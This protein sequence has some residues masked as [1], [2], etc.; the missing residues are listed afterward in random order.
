MYGKGPRDKSQYAR[1]PCRHMRSVACPVM[2]SR[3]VRVPPPRDVLG[4][5]GAPDRLPPLCPVVSVVA[6]DLLALGWRRNEQRRRY[7]R[8][9]LFP[10][11]L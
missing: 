7:G 10:V 2:G 9:K 8:P 6:L 4:C 1:C 11:R 5:M 3:C